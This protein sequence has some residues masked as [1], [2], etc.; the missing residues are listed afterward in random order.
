[1]RRV[2]RRPAVLATPLMLA[3]AVA[4]PLA[5]CGNEK[6]KAPDL[7]SVRP[8]FSFVPEAFPAL[9]VSFERPK[10]WLFAKGTPPLLATISAGRVTIAVWRYP[11]TEP[12]P[13]TPAELNTARDALIGAAQARDKTFKVV[14][15]KGTR[16]ARNPAVVVI[17]DETVA[18]QPRRVRSTHVY[19]HGGEVVIDAFAPPR[20]YPKVEDDVFRKIVRSLRLAPPK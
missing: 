16:A 3:A 20:D 10:D 15:A 6:G 7:E 11:R 13:S 5:G 14:K 18:G 9:G 17:A 1:L 4:G 19:A 12:L 8:A 2:R